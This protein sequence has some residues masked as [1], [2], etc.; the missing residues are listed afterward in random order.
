M[1]QGQREIEL[2]LQA[3]KLEQQLAAAGAREEWLMRFV[4][5]NSVYCQDEIEA[6]L[7]AALNAAGGEAK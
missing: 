6:E 5:K 4:L 2:E 7:L 3:R 1:L